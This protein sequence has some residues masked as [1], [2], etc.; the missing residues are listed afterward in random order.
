MIARILAR[1]VLY[2]VGFVIAFGLIGLTVRSCSDAINAR[3][4]AQLARDQGGAA[5]A[6][7]QDAV[8]TVGNTAATEQA[9]DTL[10][11]DN[12]REIKAAAGA[13][14][15]IDPAV[16]AAGL[17]SLC[18]RRVYRRDPKCMQFTPAR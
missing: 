16:A 10:T 2:I 11:R 3:R 18:S 15:P 4:A 9:T 13:G 8:A 7:G 14:A 1:P 12:E 17:R 5:M 6:S